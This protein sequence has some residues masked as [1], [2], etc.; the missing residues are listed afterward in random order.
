MQ[1]SGVPMSA[2]T[3]AQHWALLERRAAGGEPW[4]QVV[5][6]VLKRAQ[7]GQ[8]LARRNDAVNSVDNRLRLRPYTAYCIDGVTCVVDLFNPAKEVGISYKGAGEPVMALLLRTESPPAVEE[9][10][11]SHPG[12]Y[13]AL[14]ESDRILAPIN[15]SGTHSLAGTLIAYR[16]GRLPLTVRPWDLLHPFRSCRVSP[17]G[18]TRASCDAILRRSRH[19]TTTGGSSRRRRGS[20]GV[21]PVLWLPGKWSPRQ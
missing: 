3:P 4:E 10:L 17:G 15:V 20:T 6:P 14:R 19:G 9:D 21:F 16:E 1:R 5:P 7:T 2:A 11:I 13:T 18:P 8:E 12:L